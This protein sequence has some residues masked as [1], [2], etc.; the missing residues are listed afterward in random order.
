MD[1]EAGDSKKNKPRLTKKERRELATT[2][3][4]AK[5]SEGST[6]EKKKIVLEPAKQ[7]PKI[8]QGKDIPLHPDIYKAG[9]AIKRRVIDESAKRCMIML[10][11]LKA[12][13]HDLDVPPNQSY[14]RTFKDHLDV[15]IK[16]LEECRQFPVSMTNAIRF[17]NKK[18]AKI[19]PNSSE[20][21]Y[22]K[23]TVEA[24]EEYTTEYELA[25]KCIIREGSLRIQSKDEVIM[26]YGDS[27][28]V[29]NLLLKAHL[30][31]K[32]FRVVV[33]DS[34]PRFLG[35]S[36]MKV[37]IDHKIEVTYIRITAISSIMKEVGV[38]GA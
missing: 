21:D 3:S 6:L 13:A 7:T 8:K 18:I 15:S 5:K 24:I 25:L 10:L 4:E 28:L 30:D 36:M 16:Y 27:Y 1:Q 38:Y 11:T 26:T 12:L 9:L 19:P 2:K 17:I 20:N 22:R 35:K 33:V 37:L 31:G 32:K 34:S 29:R 14:L 23:L